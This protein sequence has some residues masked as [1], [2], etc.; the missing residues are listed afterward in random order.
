MNRVLSFDIG[1]KNLAFCD[2][3]ILN[4]EHNN[5]ETG[6]KRVIFDFFE[7]AKEK[8]EKLLCVHAWDVCDI[9]SPGKHD[10]H[11]VVQTILKF[12]EECFD[13]SLSF[14]SAVVIE[15]QPVMKNP[16]M[17]SIQMVIFTYFHMMK[18]M[19][20]PDLQIH[21]VSAANKTKVTRLFSREK[22]DALISQ[23]SIEAKNTKGYKF[24]KILAQHLTRTLLPFFFVPKVNVEENETRENKNWD[25]FYNSHKKRDDLA[26]AFLQGLHFMT[27]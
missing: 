26:D 15:N 22:A 18:K 20:F 10:I 11:V 27:L 7:N 25:T 13:N 12:L 14:L 9:S 1:T 3:E 23:T 5:K 21:L 24:N 2:I 17:K 16:I 6:D 8:Q 19:R 4:N